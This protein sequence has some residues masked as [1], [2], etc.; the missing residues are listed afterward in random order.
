MFKLFL[1]FFFHFAAKN[2][3]FSFLK[4][5]KLNFMTELDV[6]CVDNMFLFNFFSRVQPPQTEINSIMVSEI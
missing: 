3:N 5:I 1:N 4:R 2:I 6:L